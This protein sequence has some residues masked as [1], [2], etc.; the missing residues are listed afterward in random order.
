[1]KSTIFKE[2]GRMRACPKP[3]YNILICE[4]DLGA[5]K[6]LSEFFYGKYHAQGEVVV[7]FAPT[8]DLAFRIIESEDVSLILLDY[9]TPIG[10]GGELLKEMQRRD[11]RIPVIGISGSD[12]NNMVMH[13][14]GVENIMNKNKLYNWTDHC[15]DE[16]LR[17]Q[18]DKM[19]DD[20][21]C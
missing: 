14:I 8:A 10:N 6:I 3:I 11:I 16:V 1:M 20:V 18:F 7:T 2:W 12:G 21:I 5:I 4:D 17:G 9:D 13:S 15:F 19:I